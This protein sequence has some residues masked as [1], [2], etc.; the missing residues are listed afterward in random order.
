MASSRAEP[1]KRGVGG[2]ADFHPP[3][4]QA[5][6]YRKAMAVLAAVALCLAPKASPAQSLK[7]ALA[8]TY[9]HNPTL[10]AQERSV[11]AASAVVARAL[12]G[13]LPRV[14]ATSQLGLS[15]VT[16]STPGAIDQ[17]VRTSPR[18]IGLD[19][20]QTLFDGGRTGNTVGKPG[21]SC[22]L[23]R[24]ATGKQSR[25]SCST[26][27]RFTWTSCVMRPSSS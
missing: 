13:F 2:K 9:R 4:D 19:V 12:S 24:P 5:R 7:E 26:P 1:K 20:S 15:H 27:Y 22:Q 21:F 10:L 25:R 6:Y 3:R 23:P 14:N 11:P 8:A 17:T 18:G 16:N